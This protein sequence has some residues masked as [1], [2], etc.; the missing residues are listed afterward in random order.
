MLLGKVNC[1]GDNHFLKNSM[2]KGDSGNYLKSG[3]FFL[4]IVVFPFTIRKGTVHVSKTSE[5][6]KYFALTTN[7]TAL[8][9]CI[10]FH[11]TLLYYLFQTTVYFMY[12][13]VW[14]FLR[15]VVNEIY[16][17]VLIV[18]FTVLDYM[19]LKRL[20]RTALFRLINKF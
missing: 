19:F 4:N 7:F 1:V 9:Y 11:F 3:T 13:S 12:D 18:Y 6:V 16:Y 17:F 8:H 20:V 2:I 10:Y 14:A 5:S 15:Y